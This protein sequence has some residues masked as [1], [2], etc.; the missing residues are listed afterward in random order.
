LP[1][2]AKRIFLLI[3][4]PGYFRIKIPVR[5]LVEKQE[6]KMLNQKRKDYATS[7]KW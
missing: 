7:A 6:I 1:F 5:Q 2:I 3:A 4:P